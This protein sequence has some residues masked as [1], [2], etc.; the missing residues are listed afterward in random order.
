MKIVASLLALS[1]SSLQVS[2]LET[3]IDLGAGLEHTSNALKSATSEQSELEQNVIAGVGLNHQGASVV[4]EIDYRVEFT[5]FDKGTQND[6][7][8]ITGDASIVYEQID[9]QLY[10]TLENSRRNLVSDRSLT[11]IQS[12]REDRSISTISPELI[13][14]PSA[15]DALYTRLSY[16]DIRY[17]SSD[18][19]DST[20]TG[21]S[22]SWQRNLS[23]VD[24]ASLS[25]NYQDVSFDSG[26]NDYEYYRATIG[27]SAALSRL[28]YDIALGY[29]ESQR[30]SGNISGGYFQAGATY[31]DG[32][33]GWRMSVLR[34]LT[35]TSRG[36]NNGDFTGL[37]EFGSSALEVDVFE[38][39][40]VELEYNNSA[41]CAACVFSA[42]VLLDSEDY[43]ELDND[44]DEYAF[45][46]SLTYQLSRLLSL[47]GQLGYRDVGFKNNAIRDDYTIT[48][49]G[50]S[51]NQAVTRQFSIVY[52]L[53]YE[54]RDSRAASGDYDELRGGVRVA[55]L[56]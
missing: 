22:L 6:E 27:Y 3:T 36:N 31:Q 50:F 10:W 15:A 28:S 41:V 29:N 48:N 33:S 53:A 44:T 51:V 40:N 32:S 1:L 16:S 37:D 13:L 9:Q 11:N 12:N 35:D 56:F 23:K 34:E 24:I 21:A 19:Q 55:Y 39:T 7:T 42:A 30:D 49:A 2:A 20:S 26:F 8:A 43:E 45:R 5:A 17:D 4:A 14:R 18:Q 47:R 54:E 46:T 25:L 52:S 38:R